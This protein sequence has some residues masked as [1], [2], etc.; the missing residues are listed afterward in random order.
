MS[1]L[2]NLDKFNP[3]NF[4]FFTFLL[5]FLLFQFFLFS[6]FP[7]TLSSFFYLLFFSPSHCLHYSKELMAEI[8]KLS[9][10]MEVNKREYEEAVEGQR[11]TFENEQA[12][13]LKMIHTASKENQER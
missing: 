11:K 4:R 3:F 10:L 13:I 5:S 2:L 8:K 1:Y 9:A 12:G 6:L 7:S